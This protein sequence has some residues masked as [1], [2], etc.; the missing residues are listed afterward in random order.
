RLAGGLPDAAGGAPG[1]DQPRAPGLLHRRNA[2][3]MP[4]RTIDAAGM[5]SAGARA[6][7]RGKERLSRERKEFTDDRTRRP[8]PRR[9]RAGAREQPYECGAGLVIEAPDEN[10][11][12]RGFD[13]SGAHPR[14]RPRHG[15]GADPRG[16]VPAADR[17]ARGTAALSGGTLAS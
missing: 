2:G 11:P 7:Q 13:K 16:M 1:R 9:H 4:D 17:G 14:S 3:P 10:R 6:A 15:T 8:R 5:E 12:D